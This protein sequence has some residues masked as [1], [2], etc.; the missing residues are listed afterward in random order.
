M[1]AR[2]GLL[3]LSLLAFPSFSQAQFHENPNWP[4]SLSKPR[5]YSVFLTEGVTYIAGTSFL[6]FI[7]YKDHE[8]VDFHFYDDSKGWLQMDKASHA[9]F[10]YHE[11]YDAYR[12]LRWAGMKRKKALIY[13]T[14]LGF[15]MQLPIEVFDGL[16]EGYGFSNSDLVANA[17]G[18]LFFMT[19]ELLFKEQVA[20]M[21]YSY[22]PS[23]YREIRP[24]TLGDNEWEGFFYD[25]NG[26]TYWLSAN[27]RRMSGLRQIPNWLNVSLGYSG[28]WMLGEFK[29]PEFYRG[30]RIPDNPRYRQYILS[31]DV[32]LTRIKSKSKFLKF[33]FWQMNVI[34]V[35]FPALEYNHIHGVR[36]HP[37]YF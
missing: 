27:L 33:I 32:D 30:N 36:F 31:L 18:P 1:C 19:Q 15:L 10:T 2:L 34:K 24:G 17:A 22:S 12:A 21:K 23:G 37:F 28:N 11:S 9:F 8:R 3:L 5:L 13:S 14:P 4:D 25:Y 16:Y 7:W 35:P 29:N 20:T 6:S 26:A